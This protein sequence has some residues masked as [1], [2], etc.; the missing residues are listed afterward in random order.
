MRGS[1]RSSSGELS[2]LLIHSGCKSMESSRTLSALEAAK[3]Y[4]TKKNSVAIQDDDLLEVQKNTPLISKTTKE[5]REEKTRL[6]LLITAEEA[7]ER[8]ELMIDLSIG[9]IR[10]HTPDLAPIIYREIAAAIIGAK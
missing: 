4:L 1:V 2:P 6:G 3:E 7:Q 9:I 5:I 8:F 10:K